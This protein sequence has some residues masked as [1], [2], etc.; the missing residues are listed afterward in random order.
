[1]KI[2]LLSDL[3]LEGSSFDSQAIAFDANGNLVD[4]LILAGDISAEPEFIDRHVYN[5]PETVQV[6][7]VPGNHEYEVKV[8]ND[9]IPKLKEMFN[10]PNWHILNNETIQIGDYRFI[11]ST[12]WSDLKIDGDSMFESNYEQAHLLLQKNKTRLRLPDGT[13][14]LWDVDDMLKEFK[15][16]YDFLKS[17]IDK[18]FNGKTIVV[19][20]FAPSINSSEKQYK[21]KGFW[22]CDLEKLMTGV[23]VWCHGHIH[24]SNDYV[25][26]NTRV[27][28]NPRG[29]SVTYDLS[30]NVSFDKNFIF[31]AETPTKKMRL[32]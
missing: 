29:H 22:V 3:H 4:V 6:I 16:S 7:Y 30:Q 26:G 8:Y 11:C 25:I 10:F 32:K 13:L 9:V 20:H 18:P 2:K 28:S 1:M 31:N 5:I 17:E 24:S 21:N 12:L 14:R 19:T 27:L 23:E 15:N